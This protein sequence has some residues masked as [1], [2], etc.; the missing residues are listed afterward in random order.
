[1][2]LGF[3][4][5]GTEKILQRTTPLERKRILKKAKLREPRKQEGKGKI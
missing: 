3:V 4:V 5:N 1:L 2:A